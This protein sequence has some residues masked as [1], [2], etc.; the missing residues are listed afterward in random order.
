MAADYERLASRRT[1][2]RYQCS[3]DGEAGCCDIAEIFHKK[4]RFGTPQLARPRSHCPHG[5][6]RT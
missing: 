1:K 5:R 6:E 4:I 2:V 3:T